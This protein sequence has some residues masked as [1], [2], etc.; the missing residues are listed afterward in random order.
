MKRYYKEKGSNQ[1]YHL[2]LVDKWQQHHHPKNQ[3]IRRGLIYIGKKR[4][5]VTLHIVRG[6]SLNLFIRPSKA[7]NSVNTTYTML[8]SIGYL[9]QADCTS[10]RTG[11]AKR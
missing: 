7:A 11:A 9:P 1:G 10:Q 6:K 5:L 4:T 2:R 3:K 8:K